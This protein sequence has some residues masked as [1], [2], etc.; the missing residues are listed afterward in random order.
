[1]VGAF[2]FVAVLFGALNLPSANL[3]GGPNASEYAIPA[4]KGIERRL[5]VLDGKGPFLIDGLL[6]EIFDPY[7]PSLIPE[8]DGRGFAFVAMDPLLSRQ[9]GPNREFTGKNARTALFVRSGVAARQPLPGTKRVAY[10]DGLSPSKH[11]ALNRLVAELTTYIDDHGLQLNELGRTLVPMGACRFSM[12][13][14][15]QVRSMRSQCSR[16]VR[17][18]SW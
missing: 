7:G 9:L 2:V 15:R 11:R 6:D 18:R 5:G 8:L 1:M 16:R 10:F 17:S 14:P 13:R 3:S 4:I 12:P